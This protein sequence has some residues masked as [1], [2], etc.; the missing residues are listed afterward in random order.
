MPIPDPL[1]NIAAHTD[2]VAED[3]DGN[4]EKLLAVVD[5]TNGTG[6]DGENMM[7][8][9]PGQ[10]WVADGTGIYQRKSLSGDGRIDQAG[11]LTAALEIS[12]KPASADFDLGTVAF[13]HTYGDVAG[14]SYTAAKSGTFLVNGT[15]IWQYLASGGGSGPKFR[16][17]C[18]VDGVVQTAL[19][20]EDGP[21]VQSGTEN[22]TRTVHQSWL[23]SVLATKTIKLQATMPAG[24]GTGFTTSKVLAANSQM[25]VARLGL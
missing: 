23:V 8:G 19:A 16:G 4:F 14:C 6:L 9:T 12:A 25:L 11:A 22:W 1:V 17:A 15:F 13:T 20:V 3:V 18:A 7:A 2:A 5:P 24:T 21:A 10:L